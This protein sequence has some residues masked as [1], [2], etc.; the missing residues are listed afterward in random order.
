M[1]AP[2]ADS[3]GKQALARFCWLVLGAATAFLLTVCTGILAAHRASLPLGIRLDPIATTMNAI[4]EPIR[5]IGPTL[6]IVGLGLLALAGLCLAAFVAR[7]RLGGPLLLGFGAAGLTLALW[8]LFSGPDLSLLFVLS[9]PNQ[10]IGGFGLTT[11][12]HLASLEP[13]LYVLAS[14]ALA[15]PFVARRRVR[16]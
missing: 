11:W 3:P 4:G 14:A 1:T 16:A 6:G 8:G 12:L 13:M 7:E 2:N 15:L 9:S 10:W 5:P